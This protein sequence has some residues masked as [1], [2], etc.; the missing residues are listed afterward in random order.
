MIE[1]KNEVRETIGRYRHSTTP[2]YRLSQAASKPE[3]HELL[4]KPVV[5]FVVVGNVDAGKSTLIGTLKTNKLD[6]GRGANRTFVM[7]H[8]HERETGRTSSISPHL[9]GFGSNG[10]VLTASDPKNEASIARNAHRL[11][12][13]VDLAGHEKYF[14]STIEGVCKFM[15]D[16]ALVLVNARQEPTHMTKHHFNL[17]SV[18]GIPVVIVLTKIDGC[19]KDVFANTMQQI[20]GMLR[21]PDV[22]KTSFHVRTEKDVEIVADK[23]G[24][25]APLVTVSCVTGEGLDVLQKLLFQLPKRR[26]HQTKKVRPFEFLVED[27]FNVQGVGLVVSGI[28]NAGEWTKGE[29]V[30]VGPQSD[31]TY[32]QTTVR[33]VHVAQTEVDHVW[34]GHSACFA[35]ATKKM[36]RKKIRKGMVLLKEPVK[37]VKFFTADVCLLKGQGST[38]IKGKFETM[39][40]ILHVRQTARVVDFSVCEASKL[41]SDGS[42]VLRPGMI[43]SIQFEFIKRPEYIRPGMR[44]VMRDGTVRGIG[45]VREVH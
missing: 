32:I 9:I 39:I 42:S 22:A 23:V 5:R 6:D 30:H 26:K 10:N 17:T 18:Q 29:G 37:A 31:G 41:L 21:A 13:L 19:P 44:L 28:V 12:S 14:K 4:D 34:A 33:S 3:Q 20:K 36:D 2:S 38:I 40:H 24:A 27:V 8:P 16:Y 43:A 35:L 25:V 11:V 7:K 45:I 1:K 15:P